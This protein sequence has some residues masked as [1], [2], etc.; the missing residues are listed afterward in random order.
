VLDGRFYDDPWDAYR[1]LRDRDPV[2]WDAKNELWVV[3]R[4]EDVSYV[5]R[6]PELYC[7]RHG[8][9]P[10]IAAPMSIV[11]MDDPE[12]TRQRKLINRGFT[13]RQVKR[14]EP[15]IRALTVELIDE[16][17]ARGEIDF[18]EDFAAHVP[19]VV[20]AEL[21]G[22]DPKLKGRLYRWSDVMMAGDGHTDPGDPALAAATRAFTEYVEHLLPIIEDRRRAP[23]DDLISILTG[24]YDEGALD[25][26]DHAVKGRDELTS[27]ELLMF[28]VVMLVAG[29]ETTRNAISGG[30]RALSAF[31]D[32]RRKLID[33]PE[34]MDLAVDEIVRFVSPV[35]SFSRTVTRDH[36]VRGRRLREG[37]TVLM[38]YAAAN[39]DE[40]V[41]DEPD[42]FR[43]DRDPNPHVGFGVG[44]HFCLG[45]NLARLEIKAV[46]E[47][48][49]ARLGDI[50]VK[51]DTPLDRHDHALVLAIRHLPAIFSPPA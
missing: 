31:P 40:R 32:E 20:I 30:L 28:L 26:G 21:L 39:R 18:V 23:R 47:E 3:S 51:G 50:R 46:F 25:G 8:V 48:L 11:S 36:E 35:L 19:L 14:L 42:R 27:D 41:F 6:T 16:I 17:K 24:A 9:R 22:L 34:L 13:P 29:N 38:L 44:P 1:W 10:R 12:H 45:A 5:S 2:H 33:R 7:S 4:H 37:Q 43:V 49:F 15:R